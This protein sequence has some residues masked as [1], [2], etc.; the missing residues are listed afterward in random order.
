MLAQHDLKTKHNHI[1]QYYLHI[2]NFIMLMKYI[3]LQQLTEELDATF[4]I[5]PR[6][7]LIIRHWMVVVY[8]EI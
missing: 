6:C 5:V 1:G 8:E 3:N 4:D 2:E 7:G